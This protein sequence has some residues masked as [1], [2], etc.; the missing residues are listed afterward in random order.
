MKL[1]QIIKNILVFFPAV[2]Q[3][4]APML[5]IDFGTFFK[6]LRKIFASS[7]F[8]S[9]PLFTEHLMK[10]FLQFFYLTEIQISNLS[11][12]PAFIHRTNLVSSY[13]PVT[14]GHRT[15]NPVRIV[16]YRGSYR[17]ND[18]CCKVHIQI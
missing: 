8:L 9:L 4:P 12:Q 15:Q 3:F 17:G 7:F 16:S 1:A 5:S 14:S 10:H 2:G 13:L 18:Y 11:F 6:I